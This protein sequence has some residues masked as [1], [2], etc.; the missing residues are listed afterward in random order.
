MDQS[1]DPDNG[2][3]GHGHHCHIFSVVCT[4]QMV[5]SIYIIYPLKFVIMYME[6]DKTNLLTFDNA[7]LLGI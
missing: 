2:G 3:C 4:P 5:R 7:T 6:T 1:T